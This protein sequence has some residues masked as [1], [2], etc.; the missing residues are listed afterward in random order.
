MLGDTM[1]VYRRRNNNHRNF[2]KHHNIRRKK[3]IPIINDTKC[4]LDDFIGRYKAIESIN[5]VDLKHKFKN[6]E[7]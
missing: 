1:S 4:H 6:G 3:Y 5:C 2:L 7:I